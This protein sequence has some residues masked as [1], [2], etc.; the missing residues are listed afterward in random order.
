MV[1]LTMATRT[2]H[3]RIHTPFTINLRIPRSR[4]HKN[5]YIKFLTFKFILDDSW[6][7]KSTHRPHFRQHS[8]LRAIPNKGDILFRTRFRM[9]N[10]VILIP[11]QNPTHLFP[12][13][14][15]IPIPSP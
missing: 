5:E 14:F 9:S 12:I 11:F 4:S 6:T 8:S 7:S 10:P 15:N 2:N 1:E 13:P 3:I